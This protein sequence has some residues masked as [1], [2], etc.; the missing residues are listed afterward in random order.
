MISVIRSSFVFLC[1]PDFLL[2]LFLLLREAFSFLR[3]LTRSFPSLQ[4][5]AEHWIDSQPACPRCGL[6]GGMQASERDR[7]GERARA[8][9]EERE[10]HSSIP[11]APQP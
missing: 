3:S 5:G 8:I 11:P 7:V 4:R 6:Y 10:M 2:P 1:L 9:E